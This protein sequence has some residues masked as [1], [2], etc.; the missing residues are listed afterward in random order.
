MTPGVSDSLS[1]KTEIPNFYNKTKSGVDTMVKMLAEYT[2][3][4]RTNFGGH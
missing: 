2:V 3:N 1:K 4:R